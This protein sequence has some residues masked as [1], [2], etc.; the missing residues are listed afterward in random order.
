MEDL[1]DITASLKTLL[2][3]LRENSNP[4]F[5]DVL[6]DSTTEFSGYPSVC[7]LNTDSESD[8][9]SSHYYERSYKFEVVIFTD[10]VEQADWDRIR[11][12]QDIVGNAIDKSDNLNGVGGILMPTQIDNVEAV[13]DGS[14]KHLIGVI[15][16]IAKKLIGV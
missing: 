9:G 11:E 15:S 16:V 4:V 1:K 14:S 5:V 8:F 2:E 10:G 6:T 12:L 13:V 7:I 3:G